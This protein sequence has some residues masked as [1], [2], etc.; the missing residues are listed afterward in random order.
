MQRTERHFDED[1]ESA[2]AL[3]LERALS[4]VRKR[5]KLVIAMPVVAALLV[6]AAVTIIPDRYDA[7]AVVQI[8]PRHKSITQ[9]DSVV[10]DLRGDNSTVESELEIIKSRPIVLQVIETLDLRNDP[11]FTAPG[12]VTQLL[13]W[14]GI[15]KEQPAS[16]RLPQRPR[17][18]LADIMQ[19][20]TP[21]ASRPEMD[22]IADAFL[23]KLKVSRVRNTL[24]IDVRFSA[25]DGAKA[26]RIANTIAEVYLKD[27]LD[28]KTRAASTAGKVLEDKLEEM[29]KKVS[30]AERRVAQWKAE[31]NVFDAEGQL[32]DEKQLARLMEQT[33]TART[34]TTEARAK[35]EQGQK[36]AR[37]GDSGTA[38]IEVL[39]SHTVRLLK[40][41]YA[42]A[43]RRA[44]ELR[45]KYGPKHPEMAKVNAEVAE[46]NAQVRAE[47]E[48]LV[49]NLK[50]EAEVAESRE[51]QLQLSLNQLKDQQVFSKDATVEL[52][53]LERDATTSKQLYEALLMRFK[54]TTETQGFQLPDVRIIE[55][56]DA[57]QHPA[58]PKRKQLV[59]MAFLG[60][61]VMALGLAVLLE[62]MAPGISRQDDI[63]RVFDTDHLSSVPSPNAAD[64]FVPPT[65]AVRLVVAEPQSLYADAIRN[66]RRE[67][68]LRRNGTAPRLILVTSSV[69][70]EGA[71]MIA[72][73]LAH[74]YAMTGA[75]PLLID[76]DF[77]LQPLTRLLA[78]QRQS[79]LFD[80]LTS[81]RPVESAILRDGLTGL[82][83]LPAAGPV[84]LQRSIP[85]TL[86]S[87][88]MASALNELKG[89]FDTIVM[90]VP[91]L[92]PVID[93]RILADYADQIVFVVAWQ[94]TPKQLAKTAIKTLGI[95]D[96]KLAGIVLNDVAPAE[97]D[98]TRGW[99][100]GL[101]GNR[102]GNEGRGQYA[103]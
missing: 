46:A 62:L 66:A 57:P 50:N 37:N 31:N 14:T 71:D 53:Q 41:Q 83:F 8:D 2:G 88:A 84:H 94:K 56:A 11:D 24:L 85:E 65:K 1:D 26:A 96:R 19:V 30:D 34:A 86:T 23:K 75:R 43:T 16:E 12:L 25:S 99:H 67:L 72:S 9:L 36:L 58:S 95:N 87:T 90:S 21:G 5:M 18:Q 55:K 64:S 49:A 10:S 20:D 97:L 33:V 59:V 76:C 27:Q 98:E 47:I 70:G 52:N 82:H 48:R 28:S 15:A 79:G 13:L 22:E 78:A 102:A 60:G 45:T 91:P 17:D 4:A 35:Y 92:M 29:R 32:L 39:Q 63:E 6:A 81:A 61:L 7:S 73:N 101:L 44:A 38:L 77:R 89:Q 103:A 100:G 42:N 40:E 68:D 3:S 80:Q 69:A 54:Q 93:G 74:N 51:R